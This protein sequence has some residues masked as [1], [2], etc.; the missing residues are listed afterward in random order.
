MGQLSSRK[1]KKLLDGG[2]SEEDAEKKS[3]WVELSPD[4]A[5]QLPLTRKYIDSL[6]GKDE[7]SSTEMFNW[8]N[9]QP[10]SIASLFL[11]GSR[12]DALAKCVASIKSYFSSEFSSKSAF[13]FGVLKMLKAC[14]EAPAN[15]CIVEGEQRNG[16]LRYVN[17]EG[18][19][20]SPLVFRAYQLYFAK[21]APP[22]DLATPQFFQS[23][24]DNPFEC[25]WVL[26]RISL[27]QKSLRARAAACLDLFP[28]LKKFI[29]P[30]DARIARLPFFALPDVNAVLE[31]AK[32]AKE[33]FY[34]FLPVPVVFKSVDCLKFISLTLRLSLLG[35]KLQRRVRKST[36][37]L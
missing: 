14:E 10:L 33:G 20:I 35:I 36:R 12:E 11:S 23:H 37:N 31:K 13:Y 1:R 26:E 16:D 22:Q 17:S 3:K 6:G 19:I 18:Q 4:K 32:E 21:S 5:S 24:L 27:D 25:G 7:L 34:H 30:D 28:A 29:P 15:P 2:A 9:G 8:T